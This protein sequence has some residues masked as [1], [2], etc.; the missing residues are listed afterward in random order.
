VSQ[1][2]SHTPNISTLHSGASDSTLA[3]AAVVLSDVQQ[4]DFQHLRT[5]IHATAP[6]SPL[7][8][9]FVKQ[10]RQ[11]AKIFQRLGALCVSRAFF[12]FFFLLLCLVLCGCAYLQLLFAFFI[13]NCYEPF[14]R[15]EISHV[16][17]SW[18][19]CG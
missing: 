10:R 12:F 14:F 18:T 7:P 19:L 1:S 3:L 4:L 6:L 16:K 9:D 5:P 17:M 2:V 11:H 13:H 8:A 15:Q